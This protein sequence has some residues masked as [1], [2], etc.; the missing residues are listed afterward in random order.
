MKKKILALMLALSAISG[1]ISVSAVGS[2]SRYVGKDPIAAG[3][4][5]LPECLSVC[6]EL[7]DVGAVCP[8]CSEGE[9]S[10]ICSGEL[11][12][13]YSSS[14]PEIV[15]YYL[16]CDDPTHPDGCQIKETRCYTDRVCENCPY[17]FHQSGTETH[18]ETYEHTLVPSCAGNC[19]QFH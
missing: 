3:E 18:A 9:V 17:D 8:R 14:E 2:S 7:T 1:T 15:Y 19:C 16:P 13:D 6:T 5:A 4:A 12:K 11:V 10:E